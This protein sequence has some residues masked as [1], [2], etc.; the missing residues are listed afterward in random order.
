MI[1]EFELFSY[2]SSRIAFPL[3]VSFV[4]HLDFLGPCPHFQSPGVR[5]DI[6][7]DGIVWDFAAIICGNPN[8]TS[9]SLSGAGQCAVVLSHFS[10]CCFSKT[11]AQNGV[12]ASFGILL[13][14]YIL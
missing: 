14:V 13:V 1:V 8:L 9:K 4:N 12:P 10:S 5:I 7:T 3:I 2:N 11:Q 6:G